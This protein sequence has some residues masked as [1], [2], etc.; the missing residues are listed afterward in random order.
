[1][2]LSVSAPC[3][4][5]KGPID[6]QLQAETKLLQRWSFS[7][8]LKTP[9]PKSYI[10]S[11]NNSDNNNKWDMDKAPKERRIEKAW[12]AQR[13]RHIGPGGLTDPSAVR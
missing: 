10:A 6:Q 2:Y 4:A 7:S 1:M 12:K 3:K 5:K 13:V 11:N 8:R 9:E